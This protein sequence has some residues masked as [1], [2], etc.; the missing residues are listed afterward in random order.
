MQK[1]PPKVYFSA[2]LWQSFLHS[3]EKN[4]LKVNT[5][6]RT[7]YFKDNFSE[8]YIEVYFPFGDYFEDYLLGKWLHLSLQNSL[9]TENKP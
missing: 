5:S 4:F 9:Q 8:G 2:N 3:Q 7:T 6:I 1:N